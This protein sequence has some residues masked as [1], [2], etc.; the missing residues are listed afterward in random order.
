MNKL[1]LGVGRADITPEI[2]GNL[3]GY[4]PHIYSESVHDR[5][6]A[7]AFVFKCNDVTAVM[8]T[9]EVCLINTSLSDKIR[10]A[11]SEKHNVPFENILLSATHTHSGPNT[12][13][14]FGWGDIDKKYCDEIF[15]PQIFTA[16]DNAFKSVI[17]VKMGSAYGDSYVGVNR[18]ELRADNVV[19][20]GQQPWGCFNPKMTVLSF[21]DESG[22]TVANIIHYGAH[23]TAAGGNHEITRDWSGIMLDCIET[24]SG[25]V[26][27]F[28]NGFEGDVGPRLSNKG[29]CGNIHYV[30]ELGKIAAEDA[31]RIYNQI[32]EFND[33]EV[34]VN[35]GILNIPY[36]PRITLAEA[37]E[38]VKR[39]AGNTVNIDA[40]SLCYF[41]NIVKSYKEGY[42]DKEYYEIPQS[43]IAI[44]ENVFIGFAYEVFSEIGLRIQKAVAD[45]NILTLSNTNGSEGYFPT[46]DQLCMGGYEIKMFK[47]SGIQNFVDDADWYLMTE[48]VKN[49]TN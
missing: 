10:K 48:T 20:F 11:I 29:T 33:C 32:S 38:G 28:F 37:E 16:V 45:K 18:R 8:I 44:G 22:N 27:A 13:G 4:T 31:L 17:P 24:V 23:G 26:T 7:T 21:K 41:E 39:S 42:T 35:S 2:G 25:G 47:T 46:R 12:A 43:A 19:D 1:N 14:T 34:N 15:L 3:Y 30:E 5:L 49:I 36:K 6:R 40:Q 9:A